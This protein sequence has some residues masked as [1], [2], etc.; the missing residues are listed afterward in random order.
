M[1]L[2]SFLTFPRNISEIL[3][4]SSLRGDERRISS[5]V[6]LNLSNN[7]INLEKNKG[8]TDLPLYIGTRWLILCGGY[9]R[10]PW[11]TYLLFR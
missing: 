2:K 3:I 10:M 8:F 5:S 7:Q 1:K 11:G 6:L 4:Q 9:I